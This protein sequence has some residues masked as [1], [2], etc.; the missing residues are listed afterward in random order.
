MNPSEIKMSPNLL[1]PLIKKQKQELEESGLNLN[2]LPV[3]P[4]EKILGYL[5]LGDRIRSRAVS[6][7]WCLTIDSFRVK[8]LCYSKWPAGCI[9]GKSR[10]VSA[11][12]VQNFISSSRFSSFFITF[13]PTTLSSLRHLRLCDVD[14]DL[15]SAESFSRSI[16][17]FVQ[18]KELEIIRLKYPGEGLRINLD[19]PML[20]SAQLEN[21]SAIASLNLRAPRLQKVKLLGS[22][23]LRLNVTHPDSVELLTAESL[24]WIEVKRLKNLKYLYI[25][26]HSAIDDTLLASLE[27][28]KEIHV[29]S[30][31]HVQLF[32]KQKLIYGFL[33]LKIYLFGLPVSRSD[34]V[35]EITFNQLA[36]NLTRLASEIPFC[37]RLSYS[38]LQKVAPGQ[39]I[40]FLNKLITLDQIIVSQP[41]QD[42]ERFLTILKHCDQIADLRFSST[43]LQDLFDRLPDHCAIQR[44]TIRRPPPNLEF[45]FR[46]KNLIILELHL[47]LNR[48]QLI[49]R[50]LRE[51]EFLMLLEFN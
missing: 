8:R 23:T 42:I 16:N 28:L 29:T 34:N 35:A 41:I 37:W 26:F 19:L 5:S 12:F 47:P 9:Y 11:T 44:L 49:D 14:L 39:E 51:L 36:E 13:G 43:Q 18:L 30:R 7:K 33:K 20:A 3:L 50:A 6:L 38:D 31:D 27:H 32:F 21:T 24:R 10:L 1:E 48:Q 15:Q 25:G 4:F 2:D 17:S 45:L 22:N 46:L 40:N